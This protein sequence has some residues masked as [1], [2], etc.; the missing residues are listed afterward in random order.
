MAQGLMNIFLRIHQEVIDR[1]F[2][3]Q[4]IDAQANRSSALRIKVNN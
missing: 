3:L 1:V 2:H 4:G